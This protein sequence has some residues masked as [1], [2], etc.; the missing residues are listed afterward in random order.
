MAGHCR[1]SA[2]RGQV[3]SF[4]CATDS[5]HTGESREG[6]GDAPPMRLPG[7]CRA[8]P[9]QHDPSPAPPQSLRKDI[10]K[11]DSSLC[12]TTGDTM[13]ATAREPLPSQ[14][15][16]TSPAGRVAKRMRRTR[17]CPG[18]AVKKTGGG[19]G[20]TN[21]ALAHEVELPPQ[22][23]ELNQPHLQTT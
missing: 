20:R 21:Q 9:G 14:P 10:R 7:V 17:K 5:S 11:T 1:T 13:G 2:G 3:C 6:S 4:P 23:R 8:R 12:P 22:G 16:N 18:G 15:P 19:D